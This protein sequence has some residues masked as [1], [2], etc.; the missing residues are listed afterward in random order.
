MD[1][2]LNHIFICYC[3]TYEKRRHLICDCIQQFHHLIGQ[4]IFIPA[5]LTYNNDL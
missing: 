4:A 3:K 2:L 1:C 5:V